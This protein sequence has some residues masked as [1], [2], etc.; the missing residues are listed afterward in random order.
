[1]FVS[2]WRSTNHVVLFQNSLLAADKGV[3]K[4]TLIDDSV[5]PEENDIHR[6]FLSNEGAAFTLLFLFQNGHGLLSSP[7]AARQSFL[8]ERYHHERVLVHK[9]LQVQT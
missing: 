7:L 9:S 4:G 2:G 5:R 3:L 1:M 8:P 6:R